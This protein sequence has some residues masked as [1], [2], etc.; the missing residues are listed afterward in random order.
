MIVLYL[1]KCVVGF[2]PLNKHLYCHLKA[3]LTSDSVSDA[4]S[5]GWLVNN[6]SGLF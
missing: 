3:P 2:L 6:L 4:H 5:D 1:K